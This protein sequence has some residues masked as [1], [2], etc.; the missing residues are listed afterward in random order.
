MHDPLPTDSR[1]ERHRMNV[2]AKAK[3]LEA[4]RSGKYQQ[5]TGCLRDENNCYCCLGVLADIVDPAG[6]SPHA[7]DSI[8][9]IDVYQHHREPQML[10]FDIRANLNLVNVASHLAVMNDGDDIAGAKRHSFAEI[11]DWIEA[12]L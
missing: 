12:N 2:E 10:D 11:A 4:L 1:S 9:T 3:W 5:G 8:G 7:E 6:W